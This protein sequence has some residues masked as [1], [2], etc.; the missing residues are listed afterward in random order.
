MKRVISEK[1][2]SRW[3]FVRKELITKKHQQKHPSVSLSTQNKAG[4]TDSATKL[5]HSLDSKGACSQIVCDAY[6][7]HRA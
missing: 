3:V 6:G 7:T 4:L 1:Q 2:T 5:S